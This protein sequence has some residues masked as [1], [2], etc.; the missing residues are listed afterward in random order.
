MRLIFF[1]IEKKLKMIEYSISF[2]F[3]DDN[4]F[5]NIQKTR[6]LYLLNPSPY[7]QNDMTNYPDLACQENEDMSS[8]RGAVIIFTYREKT[9][10]DREFKFV[11]F[12]R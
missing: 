10:N 9:K 1:H 12:T 11:L 3:Q 6:H 7:G 2:Y 8:S 5:L 4:V